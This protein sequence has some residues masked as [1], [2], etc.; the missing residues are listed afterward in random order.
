[1][2]FA[3][4]SHFFQLSEGFTLPL[5]D[6]SGSGNAIDIIEKEDFFISQKLLEFRAYHNKLD[7]L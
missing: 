5:Q 2:L 6:K 3:D 1:M 7:I 4:R